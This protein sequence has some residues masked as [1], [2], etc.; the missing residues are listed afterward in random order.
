MRLHVGD[1][2]I[3]DL[4]TCGA[5]AGRG[6]A[7]REGTRLKVNGDLDEMSRTRDLGVCR[8]GCVVTSYQV[9]SP[10]SLLWRQLSSRIDGNLLECS[11]CLRGEALP[12]SVAR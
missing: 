2:V 10:D 9:Q 3:Y 5:G 6:M 4:L 11:P 1:G 8:E 7:E 12:R